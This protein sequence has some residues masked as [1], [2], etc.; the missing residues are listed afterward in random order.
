M[1]FVVVVVGLLGAARFV[2][3]Q[4]PSIDDA[5]RETITSV[6]RLLEPPSTTTTFLF[7]KLN[8]QW[9][10]VLKRAVGKD[11]IALAHTIKHFYIVTLSN[12]RAL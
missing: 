9:F 12:V 7:S 6:V 1:F 5:V 11:N 2:W 10:Y 3:R 4:Y 8:E